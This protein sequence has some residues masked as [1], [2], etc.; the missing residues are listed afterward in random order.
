MESHV[1]KLVQRLAV[2]LRGDALRTRAIKSAIWTV[3]GIMTSQILRLIS[4][5]ILTRILFPEAFG[6][7]ALVL[8]FI[9]G[10]AM[11]SDLGIHTSIIQNDRSREPAFLNTAWTLQIIR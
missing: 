11:F 5:L 1:P 7:M 8:V 2:A 9:T 4:N 10:L 3:G 6:T